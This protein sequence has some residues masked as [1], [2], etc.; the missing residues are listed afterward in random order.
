MLGINSYMTEDEPEAK[1]REKE[2]SHQSYQG[3]IRD[4]DRGDSRFVGPFTDGRKWFNAPV[5]FL[6]RDPSY[7][8]GFAV[9]KVSV[10]DDGFL[11][12]QEVDS[13]LGPIVGPRYECVYDYW[14]M[15]DEIMDFYRS[16]GSLFGV[17]GTGYG[18][19][20]LSYS[21]VIDN[22]TRNGDLDH[23]D[24]HYTYRMAFLN[25]YA[26]D[27]IADFDVHLD[28]QVGFVPFFGTNLASDYN[29]IYPDTF[30]IIN[31]SSCS[32]SNWSHPAVGVN[33]PTTPALG[34][35]G[36]Q[37]VGMYTLPYQPSVGNVP[38][39]V[40]FRMAGKNYL[41]R[42]SDVYA[43]AMNHQFNS[44]RPA[45]FLSAS[46]GLTDYLEVIKNNS[47]QNLQHIKDIVEILPNL[48]DLG[49]LIAKA[50]R[51]D[52]SAII[53]LIDYIT[54]AILKYRFQQKPT[55]DFIDEVAAHNYEKEFRR[56]LST[57]R[58]T[59]YGRFS[60][61]FLPQENFIGD[62]DLALEMRSK[63]RIAYDASTLLNGLLLAN[64]VGLLPT[65]SRIWEVLPFSFV[66]DWFTNM[67]DR[68]KQVD[69]Q[70]TWLAVHSLWSLHSYS[71]TYSPSDDELKAFGLEKM[72]S[73]EPFVF[74]LYV[75]EFT[76]CTPHLSESK[77]DFLRR[78]N[79]P[80]A[81]T[82]GALIWQLL[83]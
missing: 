22:S 67:K 66:V 8:L 56:L 82:V 54:E 44:L 13:S 6:V 9:Q 74:K 38:H 52:P 28:I 4:I 3:D 71:L 33:T 79:G 21:N 37:L 25:N 69:N 62:G 55:G 80:N 51:G 61:D 53:D 29:N 75:R 5:S 76:R 17:I 10:N 68:I 35:V 26:G 83:R 16:G 65:L 63:L 12:Y 36:T 30:V 49:R 60:Y 73:G 46:K 1:Y 43:E 70:L 81:V 64:S 15:K 59:I 78:P 77:F 45:A 41:N 34:T 24:I 14:T 32:L 11:V 42:R 57:R 27:Y 47:I 7:G 31:N 2:V 50:T 72:P 20:T 58:A 23:F 19:L 39:F 48:P 18:P 40:S